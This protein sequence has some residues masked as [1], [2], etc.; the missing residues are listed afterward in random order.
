MPGYCMCSWVG[1]RR[2]GGASLLWGRASRRKRCLS[3]ALK[4]GLVWSPGRRAF[5]G[6]SMHRHLGAKKGV[7]QQ[8]L[9]RDHQAAGWAPFIKAILC[10]QHWTTLFHWSSPSPSKV[11]YRWR[12]WCPERLGN[13][14]EVPPPVAEPRFQFRFVRFP[15]LCS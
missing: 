3:W 4:D 15:N 5:Q 6:N 8:G 11:I 10:A 7:K 14:S 12:S 2:E 9:G 13:L 1:W